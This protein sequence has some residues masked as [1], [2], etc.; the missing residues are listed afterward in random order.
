[1]HAAWRMHSME[2][3]TVG[4]AGDN[5]RGR[6]PVT[7]AE[8]IAAHNRRR[9][10]TS[11]DS[12]E[13]LP[14]TLEELGTST[15]SKI[16][17]LPKDVIARVEA[18]ADLE[19]LAVTSVVEE[20]L[21]RYAEGRPQP[22][23]VAWTR[24]SKAGVRLDGHRVSKPPPV[25]FSSLTDAQWARIEPVIPK[26]RGTTDVRSVVDGIA[27]RY[28]TGKS[29]AR[30]P[31]DVSAS[32]QRVQERMEIWLNNGTWWAIAA[33]LRDGAEPDEDLAWLGTVE[34]MEGRIADLAPGG[35]KLPPPTE[36]AP[37]TDAQWARVAPL[38]VDW[39]GASD[40]RAV[41]NAI[42]WKYATR[43]GWKS[44]PQSCGIA[45]WVP[46]DRIRRWLRDGT[47]WAIAD[48][49]R[50]G[51]APDEDL[52]WLNNVEEDQAR[53]D[54]SLVPSAEVAALTDAQWA[55]IEPEVPSMPGATDAR[56][57]IDA[58]AWKYGTRKRW[59]D[60]PASRH[61]T[62]DVARAR[63]RRWLKSGTWQVIA[64]ALR[65]GA[66][67]DEDLTWVAAVEREARRRSGQR[68][69]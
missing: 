58:I 30:I 1:M 59:K 54:A 48:A 4:S 61:T 20:L 57:V 32:W 49:L 25:G 62:P 31:R 46:R 12:S 18:R 29:W 3:E 27:W 10:A 45:P 60:L 17:R 22:P 11:P 37:L 33:A 43:Q 66:A 24:V 38:I 67:A 15:T 55:R 40:A 26:L 35:R 2:G 63:L 51:A 34:A 44:L 52:A 23:E 56:T 68:E 28:G 8:A 47:W 19:Q 9:R 21:R 50:N 16:F 5:G 14:N 13:P 7:D 65:E 41:V 69:A 53:P 36:V 64:A 6:H 39:P 42:A